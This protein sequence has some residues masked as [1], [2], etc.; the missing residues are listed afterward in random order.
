MP[1]QTRPDYETSYNVLITQLK[2][3]C[4]PGNV[5]CPVM[6]K[7]ITKIATLIPPFSNSIKK[8][9]RVNLGNRKSALLNAILLWF[10]LSS[11][12]ATT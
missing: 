2:Y 8:T 9:V 11:L 1:P 4:Q 6:M 5:K 3:A 10:S 7:R 12:P